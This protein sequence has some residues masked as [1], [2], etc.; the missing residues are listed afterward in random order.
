MTNHYYRNILSQDFAAIEAYEDELDQIDSLCVEDLDDMFSSENTFATYHGLV[1]CDETGGV[2]GYVIYYDLL[3]FKGRKCV[4]KCF[5]APEVRRLG[6]GSE[7]IKRVAPTETGNRVSIEVGEDAYAG[8]AFLRS[9]GYV[10]KEVVGSEYNEEG[11][12]EM[13]GFMI[14][15]NEKRPAL[16]LSQRIKWRAV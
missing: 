8:A 14:L 1:A 15:V 10:V 11:E 3:Q 12:L 4:M 5:V 2:V 6:I 7:L 13:E 16:E 9:N